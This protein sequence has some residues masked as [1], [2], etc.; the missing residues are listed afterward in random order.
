MT[1]E[2]RR[3]HHAA[4]YGPGCGGHDLEEWSAPVAPG[5]RP[6]DRPEGVPADAE[7]HVGFIREGVQWTTW[8]RVAPFGEGYCDRCRPSGESVEELRAAIQELGERFDARR[9]AAS[10]AT[11]GLYPCGLEWAT[12]EELATLHDLQGRLQAHP[13]SSTAAARERAA[14]RRA[15]RRAAL[16][17]EG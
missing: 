4:H 15:A 2:Y 13:D 7:W 11:R 12:D 6:G 3:V 10:E 5:K 16:G 8:I 17:E 9:D 14:A 1:P